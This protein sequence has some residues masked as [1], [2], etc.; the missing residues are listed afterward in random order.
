MKNENDTNI[1]QM[2]E[3]RMFSDP[4]YLFVVVGWSLV[5]ISL[6][7]GLV[8]LR[9]GIPIAHIGWTIFVGGL[10]LAFWGDCKQDRNN[11]CNIRSGVRKKTDKM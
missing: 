5:V 7:I 9:F 2:L 4:M 6:L 1:D 10:L 11:L 8:V 3:D